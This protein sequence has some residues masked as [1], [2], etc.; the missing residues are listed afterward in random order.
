VTQRYVV[1]RLPGGA[2][3]QDT[4]LGYCTDVMALWEARAE[5]KRLN[6]IDERRA[7]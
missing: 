7:Q 6:R 4:A 1:R 3:V 5:A 2:Y